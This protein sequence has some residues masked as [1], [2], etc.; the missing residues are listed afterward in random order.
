MDGTVIRMRK[1]AV[2]I[3]FWGTVVEIWRDAKAILVDWYRCLHGTRRSR[4]RIPNS[5]GGLGLWI[6][7]L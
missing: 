6:V 5:A 1:T 4:V 2:G 7:A 3:G